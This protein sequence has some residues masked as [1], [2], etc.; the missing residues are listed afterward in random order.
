[1]TSPRSGM[2]WLYGLSLLAAAAGL[3]AVVAAP[4]LLA[5]GS[6]VSVFL[7]AAFSPLCHQDPGR[8]FSL[9]GFPMA[10][11]ARCAGIYGGAFVGLL[12]RPWLRP[13]TD[14]RLP[15][16]RTFLAVSLPLA[17]DAAGNILGLWSSP[18]LLRFA[19][20]GLWG[21]ILPPYFLAGL[22]GLIASRSGKK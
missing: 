3:A 1:M 2:G 10:V 4:L 13:L 11:C 18:A 12:I 17:V 19:V 9:A 14:L 16:R 7:Y 22:G 6:R 15:P 5:G 20:G 21:L 8:C